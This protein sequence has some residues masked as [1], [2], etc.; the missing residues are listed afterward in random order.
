LDAFLVG[1]VNHAGGRTLR[2]ELLEKKGDW[3]KAEADLRV[4]ATASTEPHFATLHAQLLERHGRAAEAVRAL[5]ATSQARGRV[6]VLEQ[7]ALEIQERAGHTQGAL[8][9]LDKMITQEPR[10]DIWMIRK[11]KL[12]EKVGRTEEARTVWN[13]AAAAFE[14]L[15]AQK[16]ETKSNQALAKE[17]QSSRSKLP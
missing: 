7:L 15:P 16:R 9:R 12:L 4:A 6:P 14:K 3:K 5:D 10:P 2:A 13:Q 8:I 1:Q 11:A 17:I